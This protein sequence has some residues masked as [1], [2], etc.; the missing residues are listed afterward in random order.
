M[1]SSLTT[2]LIWMDVTAKETKKKTKNSSGSKNIARKVSDSYPNRHL[3]MP[4]SHHPSCVT[5]ICNW[6]LK[7]FIPVEQGKP[8]LF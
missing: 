8:L 6:H 3:E 7:V 5:S 2:T 4:G 1:Y